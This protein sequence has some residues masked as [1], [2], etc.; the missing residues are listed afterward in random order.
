MSRIAGAVFL[1]VSLASASAFA[2]K[3]LII[4][5]EAENRPRAPRNPGGT[6]ANAPP[7]PVQAELLLRLSENDTAHNLAQGIVDQLSALGYGVAPEVEYGQPNLKKQ[8]P[9]KPDPKAPPKPPDPKNVLKIEI[10]R[11][12]GSCFVTGKAFDFKTQ[13]IAFFK[14]ETKDDTLPCTDQLKLC[15]TEFNKNRPPET[16]PPGPDAGTPAPADSV[17]LADKHPKLVLAPTL[18]HT[19]EPAPLAAEPPDAATPAAPAPAPEPAPKKGC[20]CASAGDPALLTLW[21][22]SW[23][24]TVRRRRGLKA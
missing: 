23:A 12:S 20:G 7:A 11:M 17:D 15:I 2:A 21:V 6:K 14:Y 8:K 22:A 3:Q 9:P 10:V 18:L 13:D 5:V 19:D 24:L 1:L 4:D 16:A